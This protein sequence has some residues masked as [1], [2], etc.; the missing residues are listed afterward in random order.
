[1]S[2]FDKPQ[3]SKVVLKRKD[4]PKNLYIRCPIS[5]EIVYSKDVEKN[6]MVVPKSGYHFPL[7]SDKR[8]E[9]LID[10]GTWTAFDSQVA[11]ADPLKFKSATVYAN[12]LV[13]YKSR[14]GLSQ[15]VIAGVGAVNG[16]KVSLAVMDFRFAGGSL[17]SAEGEVLTRAIER[18]TEE[19]IPLI[20]VC[21]SGGARMHEGILSLM[22]MAK[23]SAALARLDDKKLP[24]VAILT[25]P[26]TGGVSASFATL[27]DVIIA[28]PGAMIGFA[29]PRVIKEI[30]L[31]DL[32]DGF[33]TAEFLLDKGLIDAIVPRLE[34]KAWLSHYLHATHKGK[35]LDP[36][37]AVEAKIGA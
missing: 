3:Y 15:A 22:Q 19:E 16:L 31:K 18:A 8:I 4:I 6:F 10:D 32:P 25:D 17:G 36:E 11:S 1:M 13:E 29:G 20:I 30:T 23:T 9:L 21:N 14:T 5:G 26:T 12:K 34:M 24:Y 37:K 2:I 7:A 35:Q 28:E 33:Q 27:G